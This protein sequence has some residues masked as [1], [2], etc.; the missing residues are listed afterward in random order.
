MRYID[1]ELLDESFQF[2]TGDIER[3]YEPTSLYV[4][5]QVNTEENTIYIA[6]GLPLDDEKYF[7]KEGRYYTCD[8]DYVTIIRENYENLD[9]LENHLILFQKLN[10]N[11]DILE[12][13]TRED[14]DIQLERYKNYYQSL[15][16]HE[17]TVIL[18]ELEKDTA[19]R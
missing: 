7:Y 12:I 19:G 9:D 6:N 14:H 5:C 3:C 18:N 17:K 8:I 16:R 11:Q 15:I 13:I 2:Y 4:R 1:S 10:E